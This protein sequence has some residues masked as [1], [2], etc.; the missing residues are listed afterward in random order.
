MCMHV[1]KDLCVVA[2]HVH[3]ER[4]EP[5]PSGEFRVIGNEGDTWEESFYSEDLGGR[6]PAPDDGL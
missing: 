4:K 6:E 2:L 5:I 3:R 1:K